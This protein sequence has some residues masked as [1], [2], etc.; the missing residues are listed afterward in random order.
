MSVAQ[1]DKPKT[2]SSHLAC[3]EAQH[4]AEVVTLENVEVGRHQILRA[5]LAMVA[6][7]VIIFTAVDAESSKKDG[8]ASR[9]KTYQAF[10]Q[11]ATKN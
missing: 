10:G 3:K 8:D 1:A 5:W 9:F 6:S 7:S 2:T 11:G 4:E